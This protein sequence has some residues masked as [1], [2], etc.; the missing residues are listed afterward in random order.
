MLKLYDDV[1]AY[2]EDPHSPMIRIPLK[3]LE[4]IEDQFGT[5]L[6]NMDEDENTTEYIDQKFAV[7]L[8]KDFVYLYICEQYEAL[9]GNNDL[10]QD[11]KNGKVLADENQDLI[12]DW[13][14]NLEHMIF[15][16]DD[17]VVNDEIAQ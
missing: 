6:L 13:Y 5:E 2:N 1:L 8:K 12:F 9:W 15:G 4:S 14:L 3:A 16:G 11:M 17:F 7:R 10:I